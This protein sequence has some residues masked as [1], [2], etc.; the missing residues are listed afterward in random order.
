M[1]WKRL[2][3]TGLASAGLVY[4]CSSGLSVMGS[5]K[6]KRAAK[7]VEAKHH[8]GVMARDVTEAFLAE[9]P[10]GSRHRLCPS[11]SKPVPELA[12]AIGGK[13]YQ[14]SAA[15]WQIDKEA[16]AGFACLQF[17][18]DE[19]QRYQYAYEATDNSFVVRAR[20]DLNGDG[21][22]STFEISGKVEGGKI[23]LAAMVETSPEE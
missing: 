19:P 10:D 3:V 22:Y 9:N 23:I 8:V 4:L 2:A 18:M 6:F 13:M 11:A 5:G 14:S 15:E 17:F 20:G 7:S 1:N 21:I 12:S 16:N